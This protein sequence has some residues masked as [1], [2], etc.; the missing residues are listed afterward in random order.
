MRM[1]KKAEYGLRALFALVQSPPG[2]LVSIGELARREN[3]PVKFLEQILLALRRAG[4]L[5]SRRGIGGGYQLKRPADS[6]SVGEVLRALGEPLAPVPCAAESAREK[7]P[8]L[9]PRSCTLRVLMTGVAR[10]VVS[11]LDGVTLREAV[12]RVPAPDR[13][14]FEI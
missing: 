6:I 2:R 1:S 7:C 8:C 5:A 3:A 11:A 12:D 10:D 13:L 4:F 9:D 14:M